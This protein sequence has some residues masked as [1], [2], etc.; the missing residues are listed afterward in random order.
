MKPI[1]TTILLISIYL[2]ALATSPELP[3]KVV[4]D[5]VVIHF[6]NKSKIII[7]V[8]D[9]EEL[10][11]ISEFDLNKMLKD[12]SISVDTMNNDEQ[13]LKIED[14]TG[15]KYLNDT[16][17][18]VEQNQ[19]IDVAALKAEIKE[20]LKDEMEEDSGKTTSSKKKRYKRTRSYFNFEFGMNNWLQNGR[21]PNETNALYTVKNWGS[22]YIALAN[23]NR[24]HVKGSFYLDFGA[25]I[26]W[27]NFKFQNART[28]LDKGPEE[29]VFW[30][31]LEVSGPI[32]SKLTIS[33]INATLVPVFSF[34]RTGRKRDLFNWDYYDKG[35]RIGI[36]G[37]VGYRLWSFT[38]YTWRETGTKNK[39]HDR[40]DFFL[41]NFR[42]G[43]RFIMG[44]RVFDI[45][46]NYDLNDIF[47]EDRGPQLNGLSFG[48]II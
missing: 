13:Y 2:S 45:F 36:G 14:E 5:T 18:I 38:K 10:K 28:R 23:T 35:F 41:N 4:K 17:I 1:F 47:I 33:Y 25:N 7:L 20:E 16:S 27:Y 8:D 3:G 34:G 37:Y 21:Y 44:F 46:V 30:E 24:L 42:Y 40:G 39:N 48:I 12:L 6:G 29:V 19:V 11:R 9:P 22:W 26:S 15:K 32:K 31:D 43:A